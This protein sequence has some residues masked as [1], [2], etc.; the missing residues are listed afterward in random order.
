MTS[1]VESMTIPYFRTQPLPPPS[2]QRIPE[3]ATTE[4][5]HAPQTLPVYPVGDLSRNQFLN[6]WAAGI[7]VVLTHAQKKFQGHWDPGYFAAHYGKLWVTPIDCDTD[8]QVPRM[9][10]RDFFALL[11]ETSNQQATLKL[12]VGRSAAICGAT[13][14]I[15]DAGLATEGG[16][17]DDIRK[18]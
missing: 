16:L 2:N 7:P 4:H 15:F 3:D 1:A 14:Q 9:A 10:A 12:K 18:T 6:L 13:D 17:Q 5:K 11:L 8:E